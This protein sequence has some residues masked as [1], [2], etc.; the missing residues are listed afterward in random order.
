MQPGGASSP[1]IPMYMHSCLMQIDRS[2]DGPTGPVRI[3]SR[4]LLCHTAINIPDPVTSSRNSPTVAIQERSVHQLELWACMAGRGQGGHARASQLHAHARR[5]AAD[6]ETRLNKDLQWQDQIINP[7]ACGPSKL[8]QHAH[9]IELGGTGR[10]SRLLYGGKWP[11]IVQQ[12]APLTCRMQIKSTYIGTRWENNSPLRAPVPGED[13]ARQAGP[14]S[15]PACMHGGTD[16]SSH[17]KI[18]YVC[19]YRASICICRSELE[20]P[21]YI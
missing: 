3:G 19:I 16:C 7:R 14:P 5:G 12:V 11:L 6:R 8:S 20:G 15:L 10:G 2:I 4:D 21:T 18:R 17:I 1:C 13:H 9:K